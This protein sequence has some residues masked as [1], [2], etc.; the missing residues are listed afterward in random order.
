M[1][2]INWKKQIILILFVIS[3]QLGS[4]IFILPSGLTCSLSTFFKMGFVSFL[5]ISIAYIFGK[6]GD[7]FD[8]LQ[9]KLDYT[10]T[11]FISWTYW[12][13]SWFSTVVVITEFLQYFS[14]IFPV[15]ESNYIYKILVGIL[16]VIIFTFINAKDIEKAAVFESWL[17][18]LKLIPVLSIPLICMF[19]PSKFSFVAN[20]SDRIIGLIWCFIGVETASMLGK[21]FKEDASKAIIIG[22]SIV[23]A[24]QFISSLAIFRALGPNVTITAYSEVMKILWPA[25]GEK[26]MAITIAVVCLGTINTWI[27]S[28]GCTAYE[29]AQKN[30][31]PKVFAKSTI[32]KEIVTPYMAIILSSICLIPALIIS[33]KSD[34]FS[35]FLDASCYG[36]LIF[37]IFIIFSYIIDIL[38]KRDDIKDERKFSFDNMVILV[39][40][41]LM[42]RFFKFL[43]SKN[44]AVLVIPFSGIPMYFYMRK[45]YDIINK[46][47]RK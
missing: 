3:S 19:L 32:N 40:V 7:P 11:F 47:V 46:E 41:W 8:F 18:V 45:K 21:R 2:E 34:L 28:S 33:I 37:Y 44:A 13:T 22:T 23:A 26:I 5:F 12:V 29:L 35:K 31:L 25:Y 17:T 27:I 14:R 1:N 16:F 6:I 15:L 4:G 38:A 42:V 43:I 9:E 30:F 20:K 10:I 24:I 36:F 39:M